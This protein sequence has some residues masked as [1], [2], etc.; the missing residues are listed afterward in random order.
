MEE[1][2]E[3][4]KP[5]ESEDE[6]TAEEKELRKNNL[7]SVITLE[8]VIQA[9]IE[10]VFDL[11]RSIDLHI[12][13]T[14]QTGEQAIAGITSGLINGGEQVTW[15]AWHWGMWR[16]HTSL[17]T[18]MKRP[19]FFADKMIAGDFKFFYHKHHF[20]EHGGGTLV[21][22]I[23]EFASP[24]GWIGQ[25]VDTWMMKSYLTKFLVERNEIIKQYAESEKWKDILVQN[26]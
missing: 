1:S 8:T 22:D 20:K 2:K 6:E 25:L 12:T 26:T 5:E 7:L 15:R 11:S 9:P 24:Y 19:S 4:K 17:I 3:D 16:Q 14:K 23:L 10:R 18:G 13:T 21:T